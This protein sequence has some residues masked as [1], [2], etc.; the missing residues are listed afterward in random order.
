MLDAGVSLL[1]IDDA[2]RNADPRQLPP[3]VWQ[4]HVQLGH[5]FILRSR[6]SDTIARACLEHHERLDGAGWPHGIGGNRLS[7]LGRM[8][9][10]CDAYD[11]LASDGEG[12]PGL[13]PGEALRR[14][15]AD[16]GAF[17]PEL[18][19]VF[20][21]T[22]GIWP[23]GSVVEL[24]SGRI[25]MVIEQNLEASDR[26][27]IAVFFAPATGQ[28]IDDVWIDLNTCYGAD[29]IVG[30]GLIADLPHAMQ[31]AATAAM[32]AAVERVTSGGKG[33]ARAHK[34]A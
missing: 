32:S 25:A 6:L 16:H 4:S 12:Q 26:P 22:V 2:N 20:E 30:P 21:T 10:I 24:R 19:T 7:K 23:T 3:E 31:A 9:A 33:N 18:L 14:M 29:A 13:D 28:R 34:A 17:D 5:D 8:A 1:P 15:Q 11:L 27:L